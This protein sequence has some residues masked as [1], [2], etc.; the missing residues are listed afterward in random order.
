MTDAN[1]FDNDPRLAEK[2]T[3]ANDALAGEPVEGEVQ[4]DPETLAE[5]EDETAP[6]FAVDEDGEIE[7][8]ADNPELN[9]HIDDNVVLGTDAV[10]SRADESSYPPISEVDDRE[11]SDDDQ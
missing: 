6:E 10:D 4:P 5:T 9:E 7:P 2:Q 11:S 8:L 1:P 3:V